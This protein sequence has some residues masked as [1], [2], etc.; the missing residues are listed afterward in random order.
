MTSSLYIADLAVILSMETSRDV[1]SLCKEIRQV[2]LE[3]ETNTSVY[4]SMDEAKVIY[5]TYKQEVHE[6]NAKY[7]KN[8]KSTVEA[9]EHLG[10][11]CSQTRL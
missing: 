1:T 5:Y 3:I 9:I 7:Y 6:S 8:F 11:R 4:N 2:S 10:G